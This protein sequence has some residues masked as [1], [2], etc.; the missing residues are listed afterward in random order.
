MRALVISG[1]GSKGAYAGGVAEHLIRVQ[2]NKYDLFV[3]TST[4]SLLLTHLA[5]S[6][7]DKLHDLY[8]GVS[9]KDIFSRNPFTIKKRGNREYVG[10]NYFNTIVQFLR[11]RR[12]FGESGNLKK[13]INRN[14]SRE[15]FE[16]AEHAFTI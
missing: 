2:K 4:G 8:T 7:I 1:G 6:K 3:G 12:T 9:Q 10:I 15:E 16:Q 5:I 11:H 14:I 13:L